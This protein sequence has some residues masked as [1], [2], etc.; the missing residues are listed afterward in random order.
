L[1]LLELV[2]FEN[3]AHSLPYLKLA[4]MVEVGSV[5]FCAGYYQN[6]F[7]CTEGIVTHSNDAQT[8][9]ITNKADRGTSGG[10]AV[11]LNLRKLIGIIRQHF[12]EYHHRTDLIPYIN[13]DNFLRM[14]ANGPQ[15]EI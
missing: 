2:G 6:T 12:G 13:V 1:A 15:I 7:R 10:P 9:V 11:G 4:P 8:L 14:Y 5:I 3:Q